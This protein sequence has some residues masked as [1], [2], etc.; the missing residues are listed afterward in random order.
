MKD[1]MTKLYDI[2]SLE[3]RIN[4][5]K[6]NTNL[7]DNFDNIRELID[8]YYGNIY[9]LLEDGSLYI[10]FVLVDSNISF[11]HMQDLTQIY[12][13]S[14]DNRVI[15][16][17]NFNRPLEQYISNNSVPYKDIICN[18]LSIVCLTNEGVVK[19]I[20]SMPNVCVD[21]KS[22]V[23]VSSIDYNNEEE[24]VVSHDD[25]VFESLFI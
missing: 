10:N 7:L 19:F 21:Y 11:I 15:P 2:E 1:E 6:S 13:I 24:I 16:L 17:L 14:I 3:E 4:Y 22:L 18:A 5:L 8:D 25:K 12:A 9:L 20:S 23:N